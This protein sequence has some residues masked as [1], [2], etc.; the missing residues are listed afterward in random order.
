MLLAIDS[1][2]SMN[3]FDQLR[4]ALLAYLAIRLLRQDRPQ[5]W[6]LCGAVVGLGLLTKESIFA[7]VLALVA[8]LLL[9]PARRRLRTGWF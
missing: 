1:F 8:G 4:W 9:S 2:F 6:L 5:S 7:W 3:S